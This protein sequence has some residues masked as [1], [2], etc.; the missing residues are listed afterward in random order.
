MYADWERVMRKEYEA[1]ADDAAHAR[2]TLLDPYGAESP[3]EFFAV[4]TECFFEMP[5]E[6]KARHRELYEQLM[7]FYEQDPASFA[8]TAEGNRSEAN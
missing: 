8:R 2:P 4:A 5:V 6:L 3:A 1:L 7:L